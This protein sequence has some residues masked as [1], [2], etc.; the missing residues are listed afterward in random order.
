MNTKRSLYELHGVDEYWLIHP[1]DRW[2]MVYTLD[3]QGLYGQPSVYSMD[4]PTIVQRFPDLSID[5]SFMV[6]I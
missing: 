1:E 5:W 6:A 2:I 4:E 3:E